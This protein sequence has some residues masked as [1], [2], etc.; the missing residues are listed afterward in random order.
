M[1]KI[2]H[3]T[4]ENSFQTATSKNTRFKKAKD[5]PTKSIE[6]VA[7]NKSNYEFRY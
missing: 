6:T 2:L 1:M 7:K 5:Y 4:K 3:I